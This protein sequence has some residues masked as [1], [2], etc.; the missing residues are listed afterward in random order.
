MD[1]NNMIYATRWKIIMFFVV[2]LI[3]R[4]IYAQKQGEWTKNDSVKFSKILNGEISV[5]IDNAFKRELEQ[6]FIS[7][8]T[9][10]DSRHWNDF[11]LITKPKNN[12]LKNPE[13]INCNVIYRKPLENKLF[14][15]KYEYL[16]IKGFRINSQT[17]I[18]NYRINIQRNTNISIPLNNKL[19]FNMYGNYTLDKRRTVVLPATSVPYTIGSGFSYNISKNMII[20]S[21]T[22]YQY[23]IIQK[24][25]N[26]FVD[27]NL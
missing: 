9:K 14:S 18:E 3:S 11:I 8:P 24:N 2:F 20:E 1:T 16:Q 17:N 22:N 7:N 21:Q 10:D 23:N 15:T 5:Y 27:L 25:G 4:P 13:L 6:S 26:G 12:L 19:H